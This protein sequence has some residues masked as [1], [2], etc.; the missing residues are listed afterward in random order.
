MKSNSL[1]RCDLNSE[2]TVVVRSVRERSEGACV[3]A[4]RAQGINE[5]NIIIIN[6]APFSKAL[7]SSYLAGMVAG[8]NW[9][10]C[11]DADV[12]LRAGAIE[13][14]IRQALLQP[15]NTCV[16]QGL[17]LDKLTMAIRP[18]GVHLY[19]TSLL[20]KAIDHIPPAHA[21]IRPETAT[22]E[23]M[24]L[25]G[26]PWITVPY[27]IGIHDFGQHYA[28]IFRKCYVHANKHLL[29]LPTLLP[30]W[31]KRADQDADFAVAIEG[32]ACGLRERG[33]VQ[34]DKGL[35]ILEESFA[36]LGIVEKGPAMAEEFAPEAIERIILKWAHE[37]VPVHGF[38]LTAR[39]V[40]RNDGH[41]VFTGASR[42]RGFVQ[43]KAG[44]MGVLRA[45]PYL[46]G[47]GI[48]HL[49]L[50]LKRLAKGSGSTA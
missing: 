44:E 31:R 50:S 16:V 19:R 1:F 41:T 17:M 39:A 14:L 33:A 35:V 11:L 28:D 15:E 9:T 25:E 8:R 12:V 7:K 32:M 24:K 6:E 5:A 37:E 26:H 2:V 29:H 27:V 46:A 48:E 20:Q 4:V 10:F 22:V 13:G 34:I 42:I 3:A 45:L 40:I 30:A 23:A 38:P 18:C 47:A 49:G 43:K 36:R 21:A